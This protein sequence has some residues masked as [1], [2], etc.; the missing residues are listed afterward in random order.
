MTDSE[1]SSLVINGQIDEV[2]A[3]I[4]QSSGAEQG[5]TALMLSEDDT[6][7]VE[8]S[9]KLQIDRNCTVSDEKATVEIERTIE[10]SFTKNKRKVDINKSAKITRVWSLGEE[11]SVECTDNGKYA[12]IGELKNSG[13]LT[14]NAEFTRTKTTKSKVR[15][16]ALEVKHVKRAREV[17]NSIAQ[18]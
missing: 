1:S 2:I 9:N 10:K 15:Y 13:D 3:S 17:S 7:P 11:G 8:S 5:T 14:L 4:S 6:A 12:K 16:E 18:S